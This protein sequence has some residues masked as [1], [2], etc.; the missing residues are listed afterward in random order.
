MDYK[1]LIYKHT[2]LKNGKMYVGQTRYTMLQRWS[3][4]L[5]DAFMKES[6]APFHNAIRKYGE[7]CWHHEIL[8]DNIQTVEEAN[9]R[10][11]FWISHFKSSQKDFGYNCSAGGNAGLLNEETKDRLRVIAL[12]VQNRPEVKEKQSLAKLGIAKS[13]AAVEKMRLSKLGTKASE[14]TRKKMSESHKGRKHT[15][16]SDETRRLM[17][18]KQKSI[19]NNPAVREKASKTRKE[20]GFA[21]S[22][23]ARKKISE[24][25]RGQKRSDE[26]RQQCS[27][28]NK[29]AQN[30]PEVKEKRSN[31]IKSSWDDPD[32]RQRRCEAMKAGWEKRRQEKT[33]GSEEIENGLQAI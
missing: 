4:H 20:N 24:K 23:D 8:E 2:N 16:V 10:E 5:K 1:W 12:E 19:Q 29:E 14:E 27:I 7:E 11:M 33:K 18:E 30:R 6:S 9:S 28:R 13:T 17:S 15:P 22:E 25:N 31:S 26:F 21:H 32:T 3:G